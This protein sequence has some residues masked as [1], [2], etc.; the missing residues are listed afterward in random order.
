MKKLNI[1]G[2]VLKK[3]IMKTFHLCSKTIKKLINDGMPYHILEGYK[4]KFYK[5]EEVK[6]FLETHGRRFNSKEKRTLTLAATCKKCNKVF[7]Y[8]RTYTISTETFKKIQ[9]GNVV[10]KYYKRDFCNA[11]GR[12]NIYHPPKTNEQKLYLSKCTKD[13]WQSR[14]KKQLREIRK[15]MSYKKKQFWDNNPEMKQRLSESLSASL[16][17]AW[18]LYYEQKQTRR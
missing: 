1:Q 3:E 18:K 10:N 4:I 8:C 6:K 14:T 15:K 11:C 5:L 12:S 16:L 9:S 2:Y 7:S 17:K 13:W